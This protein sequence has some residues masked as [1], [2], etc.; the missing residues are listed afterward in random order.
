MTLIEYSSESQRIAVDEIIDQFTIDRDKLDEIVSHFIKEMRKGLNAPVKSIPNGTENGTYLAL[1]LG[2]TNLRVCQIT[3][4]GSGKLA[5][6]QEKYEISDSLKTGHHSQLFDFIADCI[7][8]FLIHLGDVHDSTLS[9][10][11]TFSFPVDQ[12]AIHKGAL[13]RWTKGFSA[14]E[15]VG[16]DVVEM[17]HEALERKNVPVKVVA[18]VNDTV[19]TLLAHA[20]ENPTTIMGVIL[21]TGTNAAYVEKLDNIRKLNLNGSGDMI[22][23]MEWGAFDNERQVLRLTPYDEKLDQLSLNP[24]EQLFEKLISGDYLGKITHNVLLDLVG[25]NLLFSGR[26]SNKF[27]N[28]GA[29][30]TPHMSII[31]ADATDDLAYAKQLLEVEFEIPETTLTDRQIVQRI[32]CAVGLRAARLSACALCAIIK[33]LGVENQ[34]SAVGID[35]SLFEFHPG[36]KHNLKQTM[37]EILGNNADNINLE[38]AR[39]GSGV[40]A[41]LAALYAEK[42]HAD[43]SSQ[44]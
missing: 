8:Q 4:W 26:S 30:R 5:I 16:R 19:G 13:L 43:F 25:R 22:I 29:V 7:H 21:G 17:L 41:A 9:L 40:G 35:G 34:K 42:D 10:G 18:M 14:A 37:R 31:E 28:I 3:F 32:C 24:G 2:G 36:F 15:A 20:Y 11:F 1:D 27:D 33:H 39:D 23:N 44:L 38:Q 6:K 12:T